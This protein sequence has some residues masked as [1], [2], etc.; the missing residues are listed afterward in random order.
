MAPPAVWVGVGQPAGRADQRSARLQELDDRF[1]GLKDRLALVF[2]ESLR[3]FSAVTDRAI[4]FKSV[5]DA[6]FVVLAAMPGRRVDAAGAVFSSDVGREDARHLA[7][8]ERVLHFDAFEPPA[9]DARQH[10]FS[11]EAGLVTRGV[12][13]AAFE[14]EGFPALIAQHDVFKFRVKSYRHARGKCPR[15]CRPDDDGDFAVPQSGIEFRRVRKQRIF[16]IDRA[17]AAVL[18][19][20]LSFGKRSLVV[21]TP[22]DG[23]QPAINVAFLEELQE[24]FGSQGFV[25][26]VHRQIRLAPFAEDPESNEVLPLQVNVLF[27]ITAAGTADFHRA[28]LDFARPKFLVHVDFDRQAVTVPARQVRCVEPGKRP[29]LDDEVLQNFVERRPQMD[30]AVGVGRP[31]M[32]RENG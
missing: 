26:V 3:K 28:H 25:A 11:L 6:S 24:Y 29:G 31:V 22:I 4:N 32:Q 23:L 9:G 16:H 13:A 10:R 19:F 20:D 7:L 15:S 12:P 8:E 17:A 18:V 14:K 2:F 30:S 1:V 27:R 5:L 21:D